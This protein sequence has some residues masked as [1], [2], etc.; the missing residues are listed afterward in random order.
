MDTYQTNLHRLQQLATQM[1]LKLN[2]DAAYVEKVVGIMAQNFDAV[3]EW[4]CP[5][6]Q[7]HQPPVKGRD[8]ICPCPTLVAEIAA[9][10]TCQ[11]RLFVRA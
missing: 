7:R 2:P 11:C 10:E 6:K 5:C 4:V 3:G 8:I 1:G 9:S